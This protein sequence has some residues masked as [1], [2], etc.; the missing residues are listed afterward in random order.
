LKEFAVTDDKP[1]NLELVK[2]MQRQWMETGHVPIK[3]K[4]RLQAEFKAAVNKVYDKLKVDAVEI[5]TI[6]Y[7]SKFENLKDQPDALRI[8]NKERVNLQSKMD[9]L[10]DEI[11]LWENNIGFFANSKT[12]NVLKMEFEAKINRAKED[13]ASMEAKMKFLR[14]AAREQEQH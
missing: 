5:N 11:L 13:L 2:E 6:N 10:K 7:K 14:K 1:A 3:E 12:A 9:Q 8:I 4:E